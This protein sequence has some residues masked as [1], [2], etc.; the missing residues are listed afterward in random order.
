M[1]EGRENGL[2]EIDG[3]FVG[4]NFGADYC[5]E[6]EWGIAKTRDAF[7]MNDAADGLVRRII[8]TVPTAKV[9]GRAFAE[10]KASGGEFRGFEFSYEPPSSRVPA[11]RKSVKSKRLISYREEPIKL[12]TAWSDGD[13]A[14]VSDDPETR[15]KLRVVYDA[16]LRCDAAIWLGGG[17][18]FQNAGFVI[19]IASELPKRITDAWLAADIDRKKLVADAEATGIEEELRSAGKDWYALSPRREKDGSIVFWLNPTAQRTYN[20]GWFTVAQLREWAQDKGPVMMA[21]DNKNDAR[22]QRR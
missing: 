22:Q 6:H 8:R 19:A 11:E 4:V 10:I 13:F 1:R 14:V 17:G 20:C 7:G 5:A 2:L 15:K 9:Y 18:V 12:W 21:R 16:I 3:K